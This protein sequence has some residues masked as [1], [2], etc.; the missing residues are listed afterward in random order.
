MSDVHNLCFFVAKMI[1]C[2]F[3]LIYVIPICQG[4]KMKTIL[5]KLQGNISWRCTGDINKHYHENVIA[6]NRRVF[7]KSF[8]KHVTFIVICQPRSNNQAQTS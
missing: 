6:L 2:C 4:T 7:N 1:H 8:F 5:K 3:F